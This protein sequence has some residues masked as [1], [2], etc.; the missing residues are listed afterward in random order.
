MIDQTWPA[1]LVYF[2]V[3]ALVASEMVV[4]WARTLRRRP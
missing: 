3:A 2:A 1:V 4:S